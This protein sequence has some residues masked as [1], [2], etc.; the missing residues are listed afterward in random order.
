M[1]LCRLGGL[2]L[3][4]LFLR[5]G[6]RLA[7]LEPDA[8]E[9]AGQLLDLVLVQVVL[10]RERLELGRL[11]ITPLLSTLD[12]L[13]RNFRCK[14]TTG[15]PFPDDEAAAGLLAALPARAAVGL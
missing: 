9:L 3:L 8:L 1:R 11:E 5:L 6:G 13:P 12:E 2:L 15:D 10:E 7:H 4:G 14:R